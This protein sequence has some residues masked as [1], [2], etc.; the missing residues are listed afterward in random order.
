MVHFPNAM[1]S[2]SKSHFLRKTYESQDLSS[3]SSFKRA[4][5]PNR[6]IRRDDES[7]LQL[8]RHLEKVNDEI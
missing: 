7:S 2:V 3:R 6:K 8:A 1:G 4:L 5:N